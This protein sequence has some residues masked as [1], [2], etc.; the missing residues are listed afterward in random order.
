M[1][2]PLPVMQ[3]FDFGNLGRIQVLKLVPDAKIPERGCN[4]STHY[5]LYS[6]ENITLGGNSN[7]VVSTGITLNCGAGATCIISN[8]QE[9]LMKGVIVP[10]ITHNCDC[11]HEL[12]IAM[13]N[14]TST[15]VSIKKGDVIAS[16]IIVL[17]QNLGRRDVVEISSHD[18]LVI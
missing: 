7:A 6:S 12:K 8:D 11:L 18:E 5:H 3:P 9:L 4:L 1:I 10:T 2:P 15:T 14:M 13:F 17:C 16:F